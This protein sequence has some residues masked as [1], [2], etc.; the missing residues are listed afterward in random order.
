MTMDLTSFEKKNFSLY[1]GR[2]VNRVT[3][4][5]AKNEK[6]AGVVPRF[7]SLASSLSSSNVEKMPLALF[8]KDQS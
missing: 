3:T 6:K 8:G 7:A 2:G 5:N 1:S 4:G